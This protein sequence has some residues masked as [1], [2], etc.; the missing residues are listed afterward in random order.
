MFLSYNY[1]G[2]D[3][4]A[5]LRNDG[6]IHQARLTWRH[7]YS[8][9]LYTRLGAGPSYE[10]TDGRD[11]YWDYNGIAELNYLTERG[12]LNFTVEKL[13]TVDNFS[14]TRD[15]GFVDLWDARFT[16]DYSLTQHLTTQARIG[17]TNEDRTD[18]LVAVENVVTSD[19]P[20]EALTDDTLSDLEEYQRERYYAG[21]GFS[22][23]FWQDYTASVDY[24]F[25]KQESDQFFDDYDDHRLS[26]DLVLADGAVQVVGLLTR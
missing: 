23:L 17:Y 5:A 13:F 12:N 19:I 15:R 8:P 9:R 10:K 18:P 21:I 25:T 3:Y 20:Q 4:D 22:Y 26:F 2:T 7:D 16:F 11:A 1:I 24:L 14:G 6:D